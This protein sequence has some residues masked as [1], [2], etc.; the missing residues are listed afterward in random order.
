MAVVMAVTPMVP[1]AVVV[2]VELYSCFVPSLLPRVFGL[3][4]AKGASQIA[5]KHREGASCQ[6]LPDGSTVGDVLCVRT[7]ASSDVITD[8]CVCRSDGWRKMA[9]YIKGFRVS[10][11]PVRCGPATMLK[12]N[13]NGNTDDYDDTNNKYYRHNCKDNSNNGNSSSSG[14]NKASW[15]SRLLWPAHFFSTEATW[16]SRYTCCT[17]K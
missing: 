6:I 13:N 14:S 2:I 11:Y 8:D 9:S 3:S 1:A 10:I 15:S 5:T 12:M 7:R 4:N 16:T 17:D